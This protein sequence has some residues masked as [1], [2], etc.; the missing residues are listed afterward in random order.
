MTK[1]TFIGKGKENKGLI[2]I[3]IK[4]SDAEQFITESKGEKYLNAFLAKMKQPD[5]FGKT[6]TLYVLQDEPEQAEA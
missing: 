6:H 5:Q 1:S 4:M 2:R 3:S